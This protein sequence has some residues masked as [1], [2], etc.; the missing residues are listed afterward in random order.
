LWGGG[1]AGGGGDRGGLQAGLLVRQSLAW[2]QSWGISW[3]V[4][5]TLTT[6]FWRAG[7]RLQQPPTRPPLPLMPC[8]PHG[9]TNSSKYNPTGC[10]TTELPLQ[11]PKDC[12]QYPQGGHD[13][14]ICSD[15]G[16]RGRYNRVVGCFW[17]MYS[18]TQLLHMDILYNQGT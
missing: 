2:Q 9:L 12:Y 15:R 14:H 3:P 6:N 17:G 18:H 8:P 10:F 4:L 5:A 11:I 13:R 16:G 7:I 1:V